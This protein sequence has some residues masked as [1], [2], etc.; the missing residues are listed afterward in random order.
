MNAMLALRLSQLRVIAREQ[1]HAWRVEVSKVSDRYERLRNQRINQYRLSRAAHFD[2]GTYQVSA[3]FTNLCS[4][5]IH[6]IELEL[7]ALG[8]I[9]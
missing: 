7:M 5:T 2:G 9:K 3:G 6:E 1:D 4:R 8:I